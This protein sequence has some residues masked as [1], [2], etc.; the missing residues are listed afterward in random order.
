MEFLKFIVQGFFKGI[1]IFIFV[2]SFFYFWIGLICMLPFI[3]IL[4]RSELPLWFVI[5]NTLFYVVILGSY[6]IHEIY[7]GW[8]EHK[9]RKANGME[10]IYGLK[11]L[12]KNY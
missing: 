10:S 11:R 3:I 1:S 6:F 8:K 12:I 7:E 9:I 2:L 4:Q 5:A